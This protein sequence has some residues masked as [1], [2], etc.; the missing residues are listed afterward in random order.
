MA[1]AVT[2]EKRLTGKRLRAL[3]T[4]C[5]AVLTAAALAVLSATTISAD[6]TI[7]I[8]AGNGPAAAAMLAAPA[9]P[10]AVQD[11]Y[12]TVWGT[13]TQV[14]IF[15]S[16]YHNGKNEITVAG[17]DN[18]KVIAPGT[19]NS[20]TFVLKN[21]EAGWVDYKLVVEAWVTGLEG[22]GQTL[23][24]EVRLKGQNWLVGSDRDWRP[25]LELNGAEEAASLAGNKH[26]TYTL[27]WRWPFERDLDGD[28]SP[29]DGD[30]LDTWLANRG[31][32]AL[33]IRL[34]VLSAYTYPYPMPVPAPIPPWLNGDD[35][36]AYLYGDPTGYVR[37]VDP[38]TRAETAAI[39][40]RLLREDIRQEF[41][42]SEVL[43][44]DM[45]AS[46]WY[47]DEVATLS[48]LGLLIGYP[49]GTFRGDDPITRG[50]MATI[51]ARI[52]QHKISAEGD[53]LFDDIYGHWAQGEIMT[54]E[55]FNW[56]VGYPDGTFR[57]DDL[58]TRAETVAMINRMLHRLPHFVQDLLPDEMLTWP[59][60]ADTK[61]WYY[62]D[63]QEAT[64]SHQYQR[65]LGTRE[66][67]TAM[68]PLEYLGEEDKGQ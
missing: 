44:S 38:I 41:H 29:A 53:T 56:I 2:T 13:D 19:E 52:S 58:I 14:E 25:V 7:G 15:R 68:L 11:E 67:W 62:L 55:K 63:I 17:K 65:L 61:A 6:L 10:F 46:L 27:Q 3:L 34:T 60:N 20:Y 32:V 43:Y 48:N 57:P 23:P 33:T 35:H 49:D 30:E 51:L 45:D 54:I 47:R 50:E 16:V 37:P 28:G 12:Q 5:V 1:K 22:T 26:N 9:G 24:V 64:N 4:A 18:A 59:D 42:S 39:F 40:Y 31:D 21:L 36:L 8:G 66:K